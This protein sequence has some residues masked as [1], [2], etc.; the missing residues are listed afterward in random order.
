[1]DKFT[2]KAS[3]I[4][5]EFLG[6]RKPIDQ[7]KTQA[8]IDTLGKAAEIAT[9]LGGN[10]PTRAVKKLDRSMGKVLTRITKKLNQLEKSF[11]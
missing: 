10:P 2:V 4:L 8:D 1:M 11:K 7:K 5:N 9:K 6:M 3:G